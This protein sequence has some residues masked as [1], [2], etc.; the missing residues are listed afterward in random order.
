MTSL[1][2]IFQRPTKVKG[3]GYVYPVTMKRYD[4]FINCANIITVSYEHFNTKVVAEALGVEEESIKLLD[5]LFIAAAQSNT[6][7]ET[8]RQLEILF[9]LVFRRPIKCVDFDDGFIFYNQRKKIVIDK[10]NYDEIRSVIMMQNVLFEPKVFKNQIVAEWAEAVLKERAKN[11]VEVSM[12]DK[13]TTIAHLSGK[14]YHELMNYTIYQIEAE[15]AR[16]EK[17]KLYHTNV[18]F[19]CAG[20]NEVSINHY[21]EKTN[22]YRNPYDEL[23]KDKSKLNTLNNVIK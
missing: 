8:V 4:K 2:N 3:V 7:N 13:L 22:I 11:A 17:D 9:S 16:I 20:A 10:H 19:K 23:F 5:L 6:F 15:F 1:N 12:E 21:A 14:H 18:A